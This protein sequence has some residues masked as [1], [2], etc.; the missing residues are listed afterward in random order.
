MTGNLTWVSKAETTCKE[1][2]AADGR[3]YFIGEDGESGERYCLIY[4]GAKDENFSTHRYMV[5]S[6]LQ[7][8]TATSEGIAKGKRF[9]SSPMNFL[10]P[11][12]SLNEAEETCKI[13]ITNVCSDMIAKDTE[14][15]AVLTQEDT[16]TDYIVSEKDG[17]VTLTIEARPKTAWLNNVTF[18]GKDVKQAAYYQEA[19][20]REDFVS[21]MKMGAR[22]LTGEK[23]SDLEA[24]IGFTMSET[25]DE[26]EYESVKNAVDAVPP[27]QETGKDKVYVN[28]GGDIPSWLQMHIAEDFDTNKSLKAET[29]KVLKEIKA[30]IEESTG[31][32]TVEVNGYIAKDFN[33]MAALTEG[34]SAYEYELPENAT[35]GNVPQYVYIYVKATPKDENKTLLLCSYEARGENS[36]DSWSYRDDGRAFYILADKSE[37]FA[38]AREK[39]GLHFEK[40][41]LRNCG[42]GKASAYYTDDEKYYEEIEGDTVDLTGRKSVI[43][44]FVHIHAASGEWL[45]D[46]YGHWHLCKADGCGAQSS[47]VLHAW[48]KGTYI[49]ATDGTEVKVEYSCSVCGYKK[50]VSGENYVT[51]EEW[52]A[53]TQPNGNFSYR[54]VIRDSETNGQ[55]EEG[56][57][58][59]EVICGTVEGDKVTYYRGKFELTDESDSDGVFVPNVTEIYEKIDGKYYLTAKDADGKDVKTEIEKDGYDAVRYPLSLLK[60]CYADFEFT[61]YYFSGKHGF[62]LNYGG[63]AV[64]VY[65]NVFFSADKT[66]RQTMFS[67]WKNGKQSSATIYF[68]Y[69]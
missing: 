2:F 57:R 45:H 10:S 28:F 1:A 44:K 5:G 11:F 8:I 66:V 20:F 14:K 55:L 9:S 22:V 6:G 49:S 17:T 25:F 21:E 13:S 52:N 18:R 23:N 27:A 33:D 67:V 60:G 64:T 50:Y 51:E 61:G 59:E 30:A 63:S 26:E 65:A 37:P 62:L 12:V 24:E 53:A 4:T 54:I 47:T 58:R 31:A 36:R 32:D 41:Y 34:K 46:E 3:Y 43:L 42:E 68:W 29:D 19:V 39:N 38:L 16:V 40:A 48:D 56:E 15:N 69:D 7:E 35:F